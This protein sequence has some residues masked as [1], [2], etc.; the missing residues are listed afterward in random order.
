LLRFA[1]A[2]ANSSDLDLYAHTKRELPH[3]S[4]H[5]NYADAK[6]P[7]IEDIMARANAAGPAL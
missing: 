4:G 2:A 6:T 7:V 5:Q 3:V 1:V